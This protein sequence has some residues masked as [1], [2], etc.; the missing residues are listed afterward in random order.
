MNIEVSR[1]LAERRQQ[2]ITP[3][4]KLIVALLCSYDGKNDLVL[5]KVRTIN[6]M[7]SVNFNSYQPLLD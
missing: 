3:T 5:I 6:Q 4:L 7:H 2:L 1:E